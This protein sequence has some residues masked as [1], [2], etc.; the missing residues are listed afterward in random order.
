MQSKIDLDKVRKKLIRLEDSI[1]MSLFN[2]AQ[3]ARNEKA[4][5][6]G[7]VKIEGHDDSFFDVFFKGTEK[8]QA[9]LGRY[10]HGEE[11]PF[12]PLA[13]ESIAVRDI[14]D[15]GIEKEINLNPKILKSYLN[16]LDS[17][18]ERGDD[19]EYGSA[20]IHDMECLQ[21]IS[22]RVHIGKQV[23]EAKYQESPVEYQ[24]M[25]DEKDVDGLMEK[26]T[27][28]EVEERLFLRVAEKGERYGM[29][30]KFISDFYRDEII[31]LTKE[32]EIEYFLNRKK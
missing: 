19:N 26:L 15:I 14:K 9:S 25:I 27:N 24:K 11:Y 1:I 7:G 21:M 18:C 4:Y 30:P 29:D 10:S 2:R 28:L 31:P 13:S 12:F 23:A 8:L 17:I 16:C 22:K 32:A 5:V 6:V 3:Y 20:V